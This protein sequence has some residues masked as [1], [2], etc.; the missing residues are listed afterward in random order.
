MRIIFFFSF[1]ISMSY[2]KTYS[3]LEVFELSYI[4]SD[5][6]KILNYQHQKEQEEL[7]KSISSFYP[8]IDLKVEYKKINEFPVIVDGIE[9]KK[10]KEKLDSTLSIEQTLYDRKKYIVY[11]QKNNSLKKSYLEKKNN[12]QLLMHEVINS[13]FETIYKKKQKELIEQKIKRTDK[14]IQKASSKYEAG[15]ISKVDYLE[16]KASRLELFAQII[17]SDLELNLS[18]SNLLRLTGLNSIQINNNIKFF[19]LEN[20]KYPKN[21]S[22]FD[23]NF[24]IKLQNFLIKEAKLNKSESITGFEPKLSLSYEYL[25]DDVKGTDD[26]KKLSLILNISI[27]NGFYDLDNYQQKKIEELIQKSKQNKIIKETKQNIKNKIQNI[28]SYIKIINTYPKIIESKKFSLL[29][30]QEGFKVGRKNIIDL[31][32]KENRYFEKLNK[33][34]EYKYLFI[35]EYTS[36]KKELGN[37]DINFLK[38]INGYTYE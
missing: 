10:R 14:I 23:N 25:R 24:D 12:K 19:N 8:K 30:M 13:Y 11:K 27:F 20:I 22:D 26:Q 31:L 37:L 5:E 35:I 1:I 32:E 6:Q 33:L 18:K 7:E 2:S 16:S 17:Q 28:K 38:K 29:S 21:E 15:L 3:L 4:N 9:L 36:L 34:L